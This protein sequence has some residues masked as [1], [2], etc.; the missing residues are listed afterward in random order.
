V[1]DEAALVAAVLAA[2]EDDAPRLVLADWYQEH[3]REDRAAFIRM[4][5]AL[6]RA[7]GRRKKGEA[8]DRINK[9]LRSLSRPEVAGLLLAPGFEALAGGR[10]FH[11]DQLSCRALSGLP[12][13]VR[14]LWWQWQFFASRGLVETVVAPV[15]EFAPLAKSAFRTHPAIRYVNLEGAFPWQYYDDEY[16]RDMWQWE[17]GEDSSSPWA[18]YQAGQYLSPDLF[19]RLPPST[20]FFFGVDGPDDDDEV[21]ARHTRHYRSEAEAQS[22]LAHAALRFGRHEAGLPPPPPWGPGALVRE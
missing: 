19:D 20:L 17:R 16:R 14:Q 3:G 8:R 9:A 18:A 13:G 1:T 2:P 7:A 10:R 21:D 5:I 15:E 11:G 12:K 22:A 4:H 6:H